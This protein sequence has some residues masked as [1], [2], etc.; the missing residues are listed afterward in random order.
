M[1]LDLFLWYARLAKSRS[2]A[3]E[4]TRS[5]AVRLD[6]RRVARAHASV[7]VG[8]TIAFVQR[9]AVRV[10]RV[11]RLPQRRGPAAEAAA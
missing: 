6:G 4:L 10:L 3:A 7:R 5:G 11:M 2:V 1:R 9:D 8:A